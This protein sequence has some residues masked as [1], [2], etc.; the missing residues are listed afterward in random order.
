MAWSQKFR[1]TPAFSRLDRLLPIGCRAKTGPATP[2]N[3]RKITLS[4]EAAC[5]VQSRGPQ[6]YLS[7]GPVTKEITF[8]SGLTTLNTSSLMLLSAV[9]HGFIGC[10]GVVHGCLRWRG[11]TGVMPQTSQ[12][13]VTLSGFFFTSTISVNMIWCTSQNFL[14][15]TLN[16]ATQK[17]FQS[18]SALAKAGPASEVGHSINMYW[19]LVR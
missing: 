15:T 13:G 14:H 18:G 6:Y 19:E 3:L 16:G 17:C 1:L 2:T 10:Y 5:T 9:T 11:E 4:I 8:N 7:V 12:L